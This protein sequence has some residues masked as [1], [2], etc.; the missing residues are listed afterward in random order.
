[1][2]NFLQTNLIPFSFSIFVQNFQ[3]MKIMDFVE[4]QFLKTIL[5]VSIIPN[6]ED[7]SFYD[8]TNLVKIHDSV[9]F[10]KKLV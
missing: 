9:G 3:N 4:C 2:V 8:C 10:L 7:L 6:L 5:G 1:V